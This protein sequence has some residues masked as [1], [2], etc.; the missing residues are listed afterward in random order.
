MPAQLIHDPTAQQIYYRA[1]EFFAD[2]PILEFN[3]PFGTNLTLLLY[4]KAGTNYII[5]ATPNLAA[6]TVWSPET[7]F[8]LS[9]SF[10][11]IGLG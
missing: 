4:G 1:W 5:Q 6:A 3:P 11:F 7:S 10:R 8:T 2:P 9:N